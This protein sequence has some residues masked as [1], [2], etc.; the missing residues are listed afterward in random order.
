MT[1]EEKSLLRGLRSAAAFH[2]NGR[3]AIACLSE[4]R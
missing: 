1:E 2:S 4:R 3:K